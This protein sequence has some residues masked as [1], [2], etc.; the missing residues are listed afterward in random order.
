MKI[1]SKQEA[2]CS[3]LPRWLFLMFSAAFAFSDVSR[4]RSFPRCFRSVA[5]RDRAIL[6][7]FR[8]VWGPY[9]EIARLGNVGNAI[10]YACESW[11][12]Y[13]EVRRYVR[14]FNYAS[15][16]GGRKLSSSTSVDSHTTYIVGE[17]RRTKRRVYPL[18]R[19]FRARRVERMDRGVLRR[20]FF[21]LSRLFFC[22]G[23]GGWREE[24]EA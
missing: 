21:S 4:K 3:K 22:R 23:G 5:V 8:P 6:F 2:L 1:T 10:V 9:A 15:E 13:G 16:F 14:F 17:L 7:F 20:F 19:S 11:S 12:V 24:E 18:I